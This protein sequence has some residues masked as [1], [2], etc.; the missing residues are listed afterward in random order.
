MDK[1][2]KPY[3][4]YISR[5]FPVFIEFC[6]WFSIIVIP[7]AVGILFG[8]HEGSGFSWGFFSFGLVLG[9]IGTFIFNILAYGTITLL[10]NIEKRLYDNAASKFD[11]IGDYKDGLACV[12][13]QNKFGLINKRGKKILPAK[14]D[15]IEDFRDGDNKKK[16]VV[17][18]N[19]NSKIIEIERD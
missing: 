5:I 6:L 12:K 3:S 14:Y 2:N 18:L 19:G 10:I 4:N 16:V 11:Y 17:N 15:Y 13:C 1:S 9:F 7:I 8:L